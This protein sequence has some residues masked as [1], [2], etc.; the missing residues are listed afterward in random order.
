MSP[1]EILISIAIAV[2]IA[3]IIVPVL[4]GTILVLGAILVWAL[5]VGTTTAWAVVRRQPRCSSSSASV[6]KYLV[7]GRRLKAAGVPNRTLLV[8]ALLG[9]V[10]FF[11]IPVV[12]CSSASCSASTSPSV[13]RVGGAAGLAVDEG[14]R[15]APWA[16]RSSSSW[17]PACLAAV[18]VG[19]RRRGH[20]RCRRAVLLSLAAA[21]AYGLSDFVGGLAA[22]RTSAWPVAFVG[23]TVAVRWARSC[24]P[25]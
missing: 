1:T 16:S 21:V 11:V 12:G 10:G 14:A 7:P 19:R 25:W 20:L 23:P 13:R 4:P 15:C 9:V 8:G 2:G 22:R 18:V 6:V 24:S 3:G 17:S 5:E